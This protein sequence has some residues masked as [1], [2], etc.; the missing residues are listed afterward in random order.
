MK[1]GWK[2]GGENLLGQSSH[3]AE[4]TVLSQTVLLTLP[5]G[6]ILCALK[7]K[8]GDLNRC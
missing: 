1:R 2:D 6:G 8:T 7:M 5:E 3:A 4:I